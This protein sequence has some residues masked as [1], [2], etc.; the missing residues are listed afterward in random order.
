MALDAGTVNIKINAQTGDTKQ[1]IDEVKNSLD[2]LGS[3]SKLV[4]T[5]MT[6]LKGIIADKAFDTLGSAISSLAPAFKAA[7]REINSTGDAAQ[8]KLA[9]IGSTAAEVV[10]QIPLVGG[11]AAGVIEAY[12]EIQLEDMKRVDAYK[13]GLYDALHDA[14]EYADTVLTDSLMTGFSADLLQKFYNAAGL[15]DVDPAAFKTAGRGFR[16]AIYKALEDPNSDEAQAFM[17]LGVQLTDENG[18]VRDQDTLF[19]ET[20][21]DFQNLIGTEGYNFAEAW[22]M[23]TTL[24]G[25]RGAEALAPLLNSTGMTMEKVN[26]LAETIGTLDDVELDFASQ[27]DDL[28]QL[29]SK[30]K[31]VTDQIMGL[32][33]AEVTGASSEADLEY[34]VA[35]RGWV[36]RSI[37]P[38]TGEIYTKNDVIDAYAKLQWVND[39]IDKLATDI[40]EE[41][42]EMEKTVTEAVDSSGSLEEAQAKSKKTV[43]SNVFR[44]LRINETQLGDTAPLVEYYEKNPDKFDE[45]F[46][47]DVIQRTLSI[48]ENDYFDEVWSGDPKT[49]TAFRELL[50]N[51]LEGE[52]ILDPEL[53][54][55]LDKAASPE[56]VAQ[57]AELSENEEKYTPGEWKGLIPNILSRVIFDAEHLPQ[58]VAK[59]TQDYGLKVNEILTSPGIA[60]IFYPG[61]TDDLYAG[62]YAE[63]P[64]AVVPEQPPITYEGDHYENSTVIGDG[65]NNT[66]TTINQYGVDFSTGDMN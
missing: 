43:G 32:R 64:P 19:E 30:A 54:A 11:F 36:E 2:S 35:L 25:S 61:S 49:L 63:T 60:P 46:T 17:K 31:E 37:N 50:W 48:V 34:Q 53:I 41:M 13:Q 3:S 6:L 45:E 57:I 47:R 59:L 15:T 42:V 4:S 55:A 52:S 28:D 18:N 12:T 9:A 16:D 1:R 27:K 40:A 62:V 23:Q 38:D 29:A 20:F 65:S 33:L 10:S 5:A 58:T 44:M 14:G 51:A 22:K 21:A 66:T 24:F 8:K 7:D 26:E 39:Q 56:L